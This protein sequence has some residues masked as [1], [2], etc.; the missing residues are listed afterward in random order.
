CI[1]EAKSEGK[2]VLLSSHILAQV[3]VLADRISILRHGKIV[4]TG[5][6]DDMRHLSHTAV[7]VHTLQ[8]IP[9]LAQLPGVHNVQEDDGLIQ[10]HADAAHL[11]DIMRE[12]A[13]HGVQSITANP[14]TLEQI[15]LRHYGDELE[16]SA[17]CQTLLVHLTGLKTLRMNHSLVP[18]RCSV[19]CCAVL[20]SG[21]LPA[22]L[23]CQRDSPILHTP[24]GWVWL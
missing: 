13:A 9:Q 1:R 23:G 5:T 24:C 15:L 14:P 3:E 12:L 6:L 2:T 22:C 11:A 18:G 21:C 17:S 4:E 10:F 19:L 20:A 7:S 16:E 8:P